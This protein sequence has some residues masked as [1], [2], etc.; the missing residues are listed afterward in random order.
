[1][2][3]WFGNAES[4]PLGAHRPGWVDPKDNK[5]YYRARPLSKRHSAYTNS[6]SRTTVTDEMIQISGFDLTAA[7][8]IPAFIL[9]LIH[10]SEH[11]EYAPVDKE[12]PI[13]E[14]SAI[15]DSSTVAAEGDSV[16]EDEPFTFWWQY[17]KERKKHD[18][19][20]RKRTK[21]NRHEKAQ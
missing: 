1:M 13:V 8:S 20:T 10:D 5:H 17:A 15:L 4:N 19:K 7:D 21:V 16:A 2:V 3:Q 11:Y 18:G 6:T 12:R 9:N 14:M